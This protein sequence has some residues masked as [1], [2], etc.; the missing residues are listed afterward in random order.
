MIYDISY[1]IGPSCDPNIGPP[2][3]PGAPGAIEG[4]PLERPLTWA[5]RGPLGG[6][7]VN[8]TTEKGYLSFQINILRI[9][10]LKK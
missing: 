6:P 9:F 8:S 5:P 4:G 10:I 2:N 1:I 7:L 3:S